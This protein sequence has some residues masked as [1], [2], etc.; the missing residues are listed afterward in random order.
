MA[1]IN[2][3]RVVAAGLVAGVVANACDMVWNG[4][5]LKDDMMAMSQRL[6]VSAADASSF[7]AAVPWIVVDFVLGLVVVF[8]YAAIRPRFGAG[9]RTAVIAG[10]ILF[11]GTTAVVFGFTSMGLMP[12][13]TF[14]RGSAAS[15]VTTI[16]ASLAGGAAYKE[17]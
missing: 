1:G 10:L 12:A 6:G 2:T 13:A 16:F 3:G 4:F 11:V 9:P 7:A 14:V 8:T 5:V 15:L 17:A